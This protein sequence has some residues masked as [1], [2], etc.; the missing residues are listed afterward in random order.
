MD[1]KILVLVKENNKAILKFQKY[2]IETT[3]YIGKNGL[4][5]EK[6]EGDGKTPIGE[7]ELG[8]MLGTH[9]NV[10]NKKGLKYKQITED[11]Y[12]IDDPKSRYYNKLVNISEVKKDWNSA[13]HLIDY[14]IQYEYLIEIK[15]NPKNIPGKG[16]AIFLHCTNN[17]PTAGCIA[18]DK[19]IMKKLIEN[20]DKQTKIEIRSY[21]NENIARFRKC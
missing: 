12:W 10:Q 1:N 6:Q 2:N 4:T 8:I 18:V 21:S 5:S 11:M 3:A 7:F 16:S 14:Q 13:E 17:T 19:S 9:V 20:I 15:T